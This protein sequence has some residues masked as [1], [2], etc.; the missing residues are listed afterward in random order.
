MALPHY[1]QLHDTYIDGVDHLHAGEYDSLVR[2]LDT[3]VVGSL[4]G[5]GEGIIS[6]GE[7][8]AL[9][10]L[11]AEA[12]A[13]KAI[14]NTTKGLCYV[15]IESATE[16]EDLPD[17]SS[18]W[19]WLVALLPES[20]AYDSRETGVAYVVYTTTNS[21]PPDSIALYTGTTAGGVFTPGT[22][23]RVYVP[24]RAGAAYLARI[25]GLEA[26]VGIPYTPAADDLDQRVTDLESGAVAGG[27][28]EYWRDMPEAVGDPTKPGQEMDT[29]DA[30][31]VAAHLAAY[32]SSQTTPVEES[33]N[34]PWDVDAVNQG[35]HLLLSTQW[36]PDLP[37]TQVD[38]ATVIWDIY[39]DGSG[40]D[41]KD[42]VDRAN[43]TW[44]PS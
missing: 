22:D 28:Y 31:A 7:V 2:I 20:S 40:A 23:A 9:G 14:V 39:G 17:S 24:G 21:Q 15:A 27:G 35:K 25:V 1:D 26:A 10:G 34:Q 3:Q 6:G 44:L 30:A 29:K 38:A 43:S 41:A 37:Q 5:I 19:F 8:T 32:H 18:L 13:V 33:I 42:F 16:L 4:E 12:S 11:D 36:H